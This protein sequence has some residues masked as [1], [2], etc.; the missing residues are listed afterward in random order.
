MIPL[1]DENPSRTAPTVTRALILL[2]ALVFIVELGLGP[3]LPNVIY[4]W[5]LV[6]QRVA[7][8]FTGQ[9]PPVMP[10]IAVLTSMFLH[11]GWVHLI[12]NM[13][14]LWIF[15]DNV[16]DRMGHAWFLAF[17]LAS[18]VA[19]AVLHVVV[20]PWSPAPTVGA[21]GAIAGVLGAYAVLYPRARVLTLVPIV[22]FIQIVALPALVVL[23]FWFVVQ[24][25]TGALTL[26]GGGGGVAWWA[27]IGGFLFGMIM[28]LMLRGDR[29]SHAWVE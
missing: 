29:H 14:Y 24:F 18:G 19:A 17:N 27:H 20:S 4:G 26:G 5:G 25:F 6:P 9:E 3:A 22:F 15:G 21:S 11:G 28:A 12:G 1:R 10:L 16:E 23:G 2:N 13:W 8:V 7:G